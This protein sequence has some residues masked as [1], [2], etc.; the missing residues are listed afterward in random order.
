MPR[1]IKTKCRRCDGLG[2]VYDLR[3]LGPVG[4]ICCK[5]CGW[6]RIKKKRLIKLT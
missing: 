5:G 4:C 1:M 2:Y 6:I 3:Y